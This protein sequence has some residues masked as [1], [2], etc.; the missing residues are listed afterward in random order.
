MPLLI[1]IQQNFKS[2]PLRD[3]LVHHAALFPHAPHSHDKMNDRMFHDVTARLLHHAP[4][5]ESEN[6]FATVPLAHLIEQTNVDKTKI[7]SQKPAHTHSRVNGYQKHAPFTRDM[8]QENR[9]ATNPPPIHAH[10]AIILNLLSDL[11]HLVC[12]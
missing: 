4:R 11:Q 6:S 3:L 7:S 10:T 9:V 2:I 12:E 5:D 1:F 8:K